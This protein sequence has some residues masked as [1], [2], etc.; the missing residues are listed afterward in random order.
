MV[1]FSLSTTEQADAQIQRRLSWIGTGFDGLSVTTMADV[2]SSRVAVV[3]IVNRRRMW[4][5]TVR[6]SFSANSLPIIINAFNY[7]YSK[8]IALPTTILRTDAVA[9]SGREWTVAERILWNQAIFQPAIRIKLVRVRK[10]V[11]ITMK[12][13]EQQSDGTTFGYLKATCTDLAT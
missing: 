2:M 5:S 11:R 7:G 1:F 9:N 12:F 6:I 8:H 4:Q 10:I 13:F 3:V